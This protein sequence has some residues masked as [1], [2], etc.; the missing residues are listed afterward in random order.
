[1]SAQPSTAVEWRHRGK[2][3]LV[4]KATTPAT[5]W[6]LEIVRV[7]VGEQALLLGAQPSARRVHSLDEAIPCFECEIST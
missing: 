2:S 5:I 3:V 4:Q 7:H 6:A 1:M